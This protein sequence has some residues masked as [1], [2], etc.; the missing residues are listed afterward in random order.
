MFSEEM[1]ILNYKNIVD[2]GRKLSTLRVKHKYA[3]KIKGL[4]FER[5]NILAGYCTRPI[6]LTS[7]S[8]LYENTPVRLKLMVPFL[9]NKVVNEWFKY[10]LILGER[11]ED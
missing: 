6:E 10:K 3:Y 2:E 8:C 9:E 4:F 11:Y 5:R 1:M 7:K